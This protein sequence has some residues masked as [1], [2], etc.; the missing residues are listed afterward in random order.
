MLASWSLWTELNQQWYVTASLHFGHMTQIYDIAHPTSCFS[1]K[2]RQCLFVSNYCDTRWRVTLNMVLVS[3][4]LSFWFS[5]GLRNHLLDRRRRRRRSR[6]TPVLPQWTSVLSQT[7]GEVSS[8]FVGTHCLFLQ[9]NCQLMTD[10][11][12]WPVSPTAC[13]D[14]LKTPGDKVSV[15]FLICVEK[16]CS[17]M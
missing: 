3:A 8:L 2:W 12:Q 7:A 13:W 5:F 10:L 4:F 15:S 6:R 17:I 11:P 14:I 1:R 9:T 16:C